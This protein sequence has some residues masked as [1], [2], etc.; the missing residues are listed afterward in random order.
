MKTIEKR[1]LPK[2]AIY[3]ESN[4][5]K[6]LIDG[7]VKDYITERE[8]ALSKVELTALRKSVKFEVIYRVWEGA[9]FRGFSTE[10]ELDDLKK[11]VIAT[12]RKRANVT[13]LLN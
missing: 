5:Y 13:S 9:V 12:K 3:L 1:I 6:I 10:K 8:T 2:S 4:G 11:A 7:T